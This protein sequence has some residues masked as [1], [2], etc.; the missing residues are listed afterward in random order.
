METSLVTYTILKNWFKQSFFSI[1]YEVI[2]IGLQHTSFLMTVIVSE[3]GLIAKQLK[4]I[5]L[6]TFINYLSLV[7]SIPFL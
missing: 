3:I 7:A 4:K 6:Y 5:M 2:M 1:V